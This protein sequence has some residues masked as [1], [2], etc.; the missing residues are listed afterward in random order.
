MQR[1]KASKHIPAWY[2]NVRLRDRAE[3]RVTYF[4][5]VAARGLRDE[6]R[7]SRTAVMLRHHAFDIN[8]A[9]F[10]SVE[11][12]LAE[13]VDGFADSFTLFSRQL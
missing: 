5:S 11:V 2:I 6:P 12:L 3:S 9:R 10:E 1:S 13:N 8:F 4:Y 7:Q